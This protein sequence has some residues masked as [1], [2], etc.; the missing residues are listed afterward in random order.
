MAGLIIIGTGPGIAT[1][2]ARRFGREGMVIGL[3][4]RTPESLETVTATLAAEGIDKV[5]TALADAADEYALRAALDQIIAEHDVPDALVYNAGL[6]RSDR[7]GELDHA[8]HC[9]A[10]SVNVL[11]AL[12]AA[13]HVAPAMAERGGGTIV[14]T[15]GMPKPTPALVSLSLGK[16]GVRALADML[17]QEHRASGIHVATVTVGGAVAPG[18]LYDPDAIAEHYWQLHQ[19]PPGSWATEVTLTGG[20]YVRGE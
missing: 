5:T 15:G 1:S 12:T 7:P 17:A 10:Y 6:I 3:V 9:H 18:T 2:V 4:S 20:A 19:Q 11:G 8:A 13:T 14:I 16:A